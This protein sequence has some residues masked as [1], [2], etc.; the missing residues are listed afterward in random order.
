MKSTKVG[1]GTGGLTRPLD[2]PVVADLAADS[3]PGIAALDAR[4]AAAVLAGQAI[5]YAVEPGP[6]DALADVLD[7]LGLT[8]PDDGWHPGGTVGTIANARR[9]A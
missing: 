5:T 2:G 3:T 8:A 9:A 1:T 4:W 7:M 6:A